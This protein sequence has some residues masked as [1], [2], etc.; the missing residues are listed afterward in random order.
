LESQNLGPRGLDG[1]RYALSVLAGLAR[2]TRSADSPAPIV[3]AHLAGTLR[4]ADALA[5]VAG[6]ASRARSACAPASIASA[7]LVRTVRRAGIVGAGAV[8]AGLVD[9]ARPADSPASIIAA[10]LA[11]TVGLARCTDAQVVDADLVVG[12]GARV[13]DVAELVH[14]ADPAEDLTE[15]R[16]LVG[17]FLVDAV[18]VDADLVV[19]TGTAR[20]TVLV[21]AAGPVKLDTEVGERGFVLEDIGHADLV[22]GAGTAVVAIVVE[23]ASPSEG[24]AEVGGLARFPR[25]RPATDAQP[26][27]CI[28]DLAVRTESVSLAA[29]ATAPV[30]TAL[31]VRTVR[32]TII[33]RIRP[34]IAERILLRKRRGS[35]MALLAR[36]NRDGQAEHTQNQKQLLHRH[37]SLKVGESE[38]HGNQAATGKTGP[39]YEQALSGRTPRKKALE[40][41]SR[42]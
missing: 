30:V 7:E 6:L 10:R 29:H 3:P 22:V 39:L 14:P 38:N 11:S 17:D 8:R 28:A 1:S 32:G 16:G 12:A 21:H 4:D 24:L 9:T 40:K 19:G 42:S 23:A 25:L 5:V 31:A 18:V 35:R 37:T 13:A 41:G 20:V 36:R 15:V 34:P 26:S 27:G 2:D 33:G